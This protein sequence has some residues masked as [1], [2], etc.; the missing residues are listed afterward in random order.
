MYSTTLT[1]LLD[2]IRAIPIQVEVDISNGMPV[3]EMVGYLS[4]E[5]KEAK[6]RVRT[7]LHNNGILLPAKRITVNLSPAN[8]KKSGTGFDLAIAVAILISMGLVDESICKDMVFVGE[9]SLNGTILP[10]NGILPIV[11][12]EKERGRKKFVVPAD[13]DGEAR[14]VDCVSVYSFQ[15]LKNLIAFLNGATYVGKENNTLEDREEEKAEKDFSEIYGQ[16]FLKRA[17]EVAACGMHNMLMIGPPGAGKTMLSER[18]ATILPPLSPKEQLELSKIYSVC[19]LL[20]KKTALVSSRPFRHPHHTITMAGLTGG[21]KVPRPGEISLAHCG[22]LFLDELTE[23]QKQTIETLR[24]PLEDHEIRIVRANANVTYPADFL[25]LAAMNPCNCGYYPDMQRC[26]CSAGSLKRYQEKI[27]KPLLDRIDIC[28]EAP[29]VSFAELTAKEKA[30]SSE[31]IRKR[32]AACQEIQSER[33]KEESF[34]HNS[35]IPAFLIEE[36]C[37]LGKKEKNYMEDV[38]RKE[39]LTARSY[40]KILRVART[41]ADMEEKEHISTRHLQEAV[42]YRTFDRQFW[43]GNV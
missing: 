6:E 38:F 13:N 16:S 22:V 33:Y 34:A 26:R 8:V 20:S 4:S 29:V 19:G 41:L 3:F 17:C 15:E 30:E 42:C 5:V 43:G 7:A 14:L 25:L 2:G 39:S 27:S 40:H 10:V 35:Q 23:F 32:V 31:E 1:A 9:L 11:S 28:V 36:Y 21:G 12:D 37:A 24:Q 18:M